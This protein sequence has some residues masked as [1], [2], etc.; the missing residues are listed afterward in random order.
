MCLVLPYA[1]WDQDGAFREQL[2]SMNYN[3]LCSAGLSGQHLPDLRRKDLSAANSTNM[4]LPV[5][6][7]GTSLA[8]R[9]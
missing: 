2:L 9:A 3:N 7:H 6:F 8:S 1:Q 5:F 4:H